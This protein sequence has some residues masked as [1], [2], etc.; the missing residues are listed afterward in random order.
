MAWCSGCREP[1]PKRRLFGHTHIVYSCATVFSDTNTAAFVKH[2]ADIVE[3]FGIFLQE[4][5]SPKRAPGFFV[6]RSK[7][8]HIALQ[9]DFL[10][11]ERQHCRE[12]HDRRPFVVKRAAAPNHAVFD[13]PA[14]G[15]RLPEF[16][17]RR[18]NIHVVE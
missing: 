5:S 1:Q 13:L 8:D 11:L 14:K 16:F 10:P 7:K 18:D 17:V 6:G 12:F 9:S 3:Q 15:F 2:Q 4:V